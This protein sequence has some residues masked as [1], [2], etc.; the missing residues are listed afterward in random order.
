M[1]VEVGLAMAGGVELTT[2]I[3]VP[4]AIVFGRHLENL[5]VNIQNVDILP[6][7]TAAVEYAPLTHADTR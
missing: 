6:S 5:D 1:T 4:V 7:E 3:S 2:G